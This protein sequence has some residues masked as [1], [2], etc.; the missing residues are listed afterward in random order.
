MQGR[1]VV[2]AC[3][4]VSETWFEDQGRGRIA[5]GEVGVR[6][7]GRREGRLEEEER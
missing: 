5:I 2:V 6:S 7:K 3:H 1:L 4:E